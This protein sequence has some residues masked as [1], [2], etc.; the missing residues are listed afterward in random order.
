MQVSIEQVKHVNIYQT[1]DNDGH[2]KIKASKNCFSI[3]LE[4]LD[5]L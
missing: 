5:F 3:F 4:K 1:F 2:L